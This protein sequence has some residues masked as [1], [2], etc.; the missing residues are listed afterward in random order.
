MIEQSSTLSKNI[1]VMF[2]SAPP[3]SNP[4]KESTEGKKLSKINVEIIH[5]NYVKKRIESSIFT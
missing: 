4:I 5:S 1:V 2:I 3:Q